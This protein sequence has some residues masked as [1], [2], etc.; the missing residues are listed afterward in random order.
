MKKYIIILLSIAF[1]GCE[2]S[3]DL[4]KNRSI[5]TSL[6]KNQISTLINTKSNFKT[7]Y[8]NT[9]KKLKRNKYET[10]SEYK[11]K[12]KNINTI[13]VVVLESKGKYYPDDGV[14]RINFWVSTPVMK[15]I[16]H[17]KQGVLDEFN[18]DIETPDDWFN[19]LAITMGKSS[20]ME[21]LE[22]NAFGAQ[23]YVDNTYK[24]G[25]TA[26][27]NNLKNIINS[28]NNLALDR[29]KDY[30][31]L[32]F[33]ISR[34][35]AKKYDKQKFKLKAEITLTDIE[36]SMF[37]TTYFKDATISSTYRDTHHNYVVS[38]HINKLIIYN[39]STKK[40]LFTH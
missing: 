7:A 14:Y 18:M 20:R 15:W 22:S 4:N 9:L 8:N 26:L 10:S 31:T 19:T 12:I 2:N 36:K 27:P 13:A 23:A 33:P 39:H 16:H 28:H 38:V 11:N 21:T 5:K 24:T 30:M 40:V 17:Y 6:T 25:Y 29:D 1:V 3:P 37:R 32:S 35:L 34:E